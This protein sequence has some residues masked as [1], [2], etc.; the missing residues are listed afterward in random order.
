MSLELVG[1]MAA[2]AYDMFLDTVRDYILVHN[3]EP[4]VVHVSQ[5]MEQM[6]M[7]HM[8]MNC[9]MQFP[10]GGLRGMT[11][12]MGMR[13]IWDAVHFKLEREPCHLIHWSVRIIM[14]PEL[15]QSENSHLLVGSS[16]SPSA[17]RLMMDPMYDCPYTSLAVMGSPIL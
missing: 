7:A 5:A 2:A 12:I 10:L 3:E 8:S 16:I 14:L 17:A 9:N 11:H 13:P 4:N 6:L 15:A 1:E